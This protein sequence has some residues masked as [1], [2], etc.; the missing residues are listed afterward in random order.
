[1]TKKQFFRYYTCLTKG[2]FTWIT[3]AA[4]I[5]FGTTAVGT[6]SIFVPA[7]TAY[8]SY[9]AAAVIVYLAGAILC[10]TVVRDT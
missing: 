9:L 10:T 3:A 2:I 1:M 8:L 4:S 5:V 7:P 6:D